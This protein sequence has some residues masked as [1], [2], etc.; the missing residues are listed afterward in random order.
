MMGLPR[1][2]LPDAPEG[3]GA[4]MHIEFRHHAMGVTSAALFADNGLLV[5]EVRGHSFR[6]AYDN[7]RDQYP[8]AT[9]DGA[10]AEEDEDV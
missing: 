2:P 9:W 4:G 7:V 3:E 1:L 5:D 8:Q 10:E 6:E